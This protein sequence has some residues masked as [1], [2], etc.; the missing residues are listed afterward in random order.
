MPHCQLTLSLLEAW[1]L[2]VDHIQPAL[3]PHD[4]TIG[5]ALLDGCTN[6]HDISFFLFVPENYSSSGQ[7]IRAHFHPHFI[8]RQYPDIIHPHFSR[9]GGQYFVTIFQLYPEHCIGQGFQNNS[10][11]FN[12]R[13]FSHIRLRRRKDRIITRNYEK[14][15]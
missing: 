11:L 3:S 7:I 6:F 10:I 14:I 13:L 12:Q 15:T 1:I 5:A 9:D 8:T 4:L 2:F